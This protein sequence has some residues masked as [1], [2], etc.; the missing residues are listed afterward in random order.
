MADSKNGPKHGSERLYRMGC[1]CFTCRIKHANRYAADRA[2][3]EARPTPDS[4]HGT[5]GG[6]TN[7]G[8]R[9]V[10]CTHAQTTYC[11]ARRFT[12]TRR[13]A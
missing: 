8:C 3:R 9:C 11:H 13:H 4:V 7:W 1:R 6:Y 5:R 2:Q 10:D 12:Q